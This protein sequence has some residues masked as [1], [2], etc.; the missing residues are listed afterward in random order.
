MPLVSRRLLLFGALVPLVAGTLSGCDSTTESVDDPI[1]VGYAGA[2]L[3][4]PFSL[5]LSQGINGGA[6]EMGLRLTET[7]AG[8]DAARQAIDVANLLDEKVDV[9][10]INPVD[11]A[12]AAAAF[13]AAR[14]KKVPVFTVGSERIAGEIVSSIRSDDYAVGARAA[15]WTVQSLIARY[16]TANG[17]VVSLAS[18]E[19]A[20]GF[21]SGLRSFPGVS[22]VGLPTVTGEEEAYLT[23][24]EQLYGATPVDVIF[25]TTDDVVTGAVRAANEVARREWPAVAIVRVGTSPESLLGLEDGT[26]QAAVT[27]D[28][29]GLARFALRLVERKFAGE[30]VARDYA[31]PTTLHVAP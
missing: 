3:A 14:E 16:G 30:T 19:I 31:F 8:G 2:D 15:A 27:R 23:V 7:N 24:L 25:G 5:R 17:R 12:T 18:S 11:R 6:R 4:D 28:P 20:A 13:E 29:A 26:V 9:L 21:A 22:V 10:V 1:S